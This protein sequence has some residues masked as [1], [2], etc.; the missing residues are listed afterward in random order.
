MTHAL[1]GALSIA[2]VMAFI[3]TAVVEHDGAGTFFFF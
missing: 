3:G 2:F 1:V